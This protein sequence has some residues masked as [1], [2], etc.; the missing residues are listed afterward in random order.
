MRSSLLAAFACLV[1]GILCQAT[2]AQEAPRLTIPISQLDRSTLAGNI[3]AKLIRATD[4]GPVQPDHVIGRM[5]LMLRPSAHCGLPLICE[6]SRSPEGVGN[7]PICRAQ[8]A[9]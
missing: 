8:P 2:Q 7:S 9:Q 6:V 4:E 5:M 1:T 3:P